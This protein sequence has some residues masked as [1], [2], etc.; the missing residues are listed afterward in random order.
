MVVSVMDDDPALYD[1]LGVRLSDADPARSLT[2]HPSPVTLREQI[3]MDHTP[4]E[5]ASPESASPE[6]ASPQPPG[7][8]RRRARW[9]PQL[10]ASVA[11][12]VAVVLLVS[13]ALPGGGPSAVLAPALADEYLD[14]SPLASAPPTSW[15][16]S[17]VSP[18]NETGSVG[19]IASDM[20]QG[21]TGLEELDAVALLELVGLPWRVV[22][23]DGEYFMV[24]KDFSP[25]R[26][27]LTV[28]AG[29]VVA[30]SLG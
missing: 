29:F 17:G 2:P 18:G 10:A 9:A 28:A 12:S 14:S 22:S 15:L 11:A 16:D 5:S 30:A 6:S 8:H 13:T 19:G 27:N 24:T 21:V 25:D 4:P 20:A 23:R 1:E 26:I 7:R 3:I